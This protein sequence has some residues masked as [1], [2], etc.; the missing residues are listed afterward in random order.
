MN[1]TERYIELLKKSL[2][3]EIYIENEIKLFYIIHCLVEKRPVSYGYLVNPEKITGGLVQTVKYA[4]DIGATVTLHVKNSEGQMQP[5]HHLRNILEFPH[6]MIGRKR[7]DNLHYCIEKVLSDDIPGDLIETGVWRGGATILMRGILAAHNVID[8]TVWVADSFE[9]LPSPTLKQDQGINL[10]K[11][12][13]PVLSVGLDKVKELFL[14]YD[15]LDDQVRFLK[16]WFKDTL[17]EAQ[18][19]QLSI[20]RLDGDLYESTMDAFRA[21]YDKVSIGGFVIIDDYNALEVCKM[22]VHDFRKEK[23]IDDEIIKIDNTSV[24]WVKSKH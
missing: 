6:S 20:L 21:L 15:L 4:K 22:A 14:R 18:I 2:I 11:D 13:F 5:A 16:G 9:G 3:N 23:H 7:V 8:R 10:T 12:Y 19:E 24:Y 17:P 1:L